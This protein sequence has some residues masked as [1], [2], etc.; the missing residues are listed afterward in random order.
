MSSVGHELVHREQFRRAKAN[1]KKANQHY[2]RKTSRFGDPYEQSDPKK[3]SAALHA[4]FEH[5]YEVMAYA[6]SIAQSLK[7]QYG[8]R[9]LDVLR[10]GEWKWGARDYETAHMPIYYKSGRPETRR[11]LKYV[12]AYLGEAE[13][14]KGMLCNYCVGRARG[15]I[16]VETPKSVFMQITRP[17]WIGAGLWVMMPNRMRR[18]QLGHVFFH[19]SGDRKYHMR[20]VLGEPNSVTCAQQFDTAEEAKAALVDLLKRK[21]LIRTEPRTMG[22][23]RNPDGTHRE[24][25]ESN[26]RRK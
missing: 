16:E 3:V 11:L 7:K 26:I 23:E 24:W 25:V 4:Y 5:P 1:A 13:T 17:V 6:Y 14:P 15:I 19:G 20:D 22:W 8:A 18:H 12:A 10:S 21:G 2:V 9:A